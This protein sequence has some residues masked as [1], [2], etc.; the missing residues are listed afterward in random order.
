MLKRLSRSGNDLQQKTGRACLKKRS[1][2]ISLT[3]FII[4]AY[5]RCMPENPLYWMNAV[6]HIKLPQHLVTDLSAAD[7]PSSETG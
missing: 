6:Q 2:N 5:D 7:R 4:Q 3:E 1:R